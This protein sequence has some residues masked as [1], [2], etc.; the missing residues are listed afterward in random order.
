MEWK[1]K[2]RK[3]KERKERKKEKGRKEEKRKKEKKYKIWGVT[4]TLA[5]LSF[6]VLSNDLVMILVSLSWHSRDSLTFQ[7][8]QHN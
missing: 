6:V 5:V 3:G 1:G 2:E 4:T 7:L 8:L